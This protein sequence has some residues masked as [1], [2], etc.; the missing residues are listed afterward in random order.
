[1]AIYCDIVE[2]GND[3]NVAL[4]KLSSEFAA[5][6]GE[7]WEKEKKAHYKKAYSPNIGA[8]ARM[9][10]EKTMKLFFA[11]DS[12]TNKPVGYMIGL[13]FRPLPYESTVFRIEDC[14]G[15]PEAKQALYAYMKQAVRFLG[16]D[17]MWVT[18]APNLIPDLS[19]T[20][21]RRDGEFI[22]HRYIKG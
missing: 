7:C 3:L 8:I 19:D 18:D 22:M 15:S 14:Y 4:Q 17:E 2:P 12:Q 16:V 9:W 13:V 21:W 5:M 6:Y 1:M 11:Y 10:F 20:S